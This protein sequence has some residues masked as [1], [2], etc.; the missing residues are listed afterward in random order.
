MQAHVSARRQSRTECHCCDHHRCDTDI[1]AALTIVAMASMFDLPEDLPEEQDEA[2]VLPVPSSSPAPLTDAHDDAAVPPSPS[3]SPS[4][5]TTFSPPPS[6][7]PFELTDLSVH[8]FDTKDEVFTFLR[9]HAAHRGFELVFKTTGGGAAGRHGGTARCWC[10]GVPKAPTAASIMHTVEPIRRGAPTNVTKGGKKLLAGCVWQVPFNRHQSR[11]GRPEYAITK[12]VLRHTG[13]QLLP[14]DAVTHCINSLTKITPAMQAAVVAMISSG[15]HGV[16]AERRFLMQTHGIDLERNVFHSLVTK[17]KRELGI[18]DGAGDWRALLEWLQEEMATSSAIARYHVDETVGYEIDAVFY[19]STDMRHHLA[20]NGV[21]LIMD[22]TFKTNR[23]HWPLLLV[24]GINEHSQSIIL[25]VALLHHQTT[26]AF[27]WALQLMRGAVSQEAWDSVATVVTDG[28]SAM[29]AAI[30]EVLPLA[31]H[32]RCRYHL[33]QN[34]R[35][36]LVD[37]VGLIP[38]EDFVTQWRA[39]VNMEEM[40]DFQRGKAILHGAYPA[41]VD[42]LEQYHWINEDKFAECI[43][44]Q[45]TTLGIRSTS[46]VEGWNSK[47]KG[48]F[49]VRGVTSLRVLFDTL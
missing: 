2:V 22:T 31:H 47:L 35:S 49:Q 28:D 3:A 8:V 45:Y 9:N 29:S 33:E 15:M 41:A 17:T 1:A 32:I 37:V 23:F 14:P 40:E 6:A 13:H 39:V 5:P 10:S 21:V 16:E 34:L 27:T 20:R 43:I 4:P 24:C 30:A 7:I 19:M 46:R 25:A 44:K 42:Y 48:M 18:V 36:Q 38:M 11:D 26:L 12:R